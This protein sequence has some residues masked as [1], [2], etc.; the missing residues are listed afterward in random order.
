MRGSIGGQVLKPFGVAKKWAMLVMN[1]YFAV[2]D[3]F[4]L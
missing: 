4:F 3:E 1:E 2:T